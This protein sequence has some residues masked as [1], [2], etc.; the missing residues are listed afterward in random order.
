MGIEQLTLADLAM[1]NRKTLGD[2]VPIQVF[3]MIR[4]IGMHKML[5]ESAGHAIYTAGKSLGGALEVKTVPEFLDLVR[6]LRIGIPKVTASGEDRVVVLVE[7]CITCSGVTNVGEM[8]CHLEGGIIAGALEKILKRPARAAQTQSSS[9][10]FNGCEFE[11][12]LF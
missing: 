10:G 1:S 6:S 3:R 5:G 9:M 8:F 12:H 2:E 4:L 7:E 11:V